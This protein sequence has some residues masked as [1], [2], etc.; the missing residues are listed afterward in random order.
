MKTDTKLKMHRITPKRV[1]CYGL[2]CWVINKCDARKQEYDSINAL[3]TSNL[4][5]RLLHEF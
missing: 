1:M 5:N 2:E 4:L 3:F